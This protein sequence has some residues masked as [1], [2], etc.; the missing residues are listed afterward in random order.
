M[1]NAVSQTKYHEHKDIHHPQNAQESYPL[2]RQTA[3]LYQ[4]IS[5]VG[6][7]WQLSLDQIKRLLGL[8]KKTEISTC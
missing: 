4:L 3:I 5:I 8:D 1:T 6:H 2:W 7:L